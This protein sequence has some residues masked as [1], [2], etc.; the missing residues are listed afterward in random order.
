VFLAFA[1]WFLRL[2]GRLDLVWLELSGDESHAWV[3]ARTETGPLL[4]EGL[5]RIR[6]SHPACPFLRGLKEHEGNGRYRLAGDQVWAFLDAVAGTR[7]ARLEAVARVPWKKV[8]FR[9]LEVEAAIDS[10]VPSLAVRYSGQARWARGRWMRLGDEWWDARLTDEHA[11]L[12]LKGSVTYGPERLRHVLADFAP[13]WNVRGTIWK[14]DPNRSLTRAS[15]EPAED[16]SIAV[17]CEYLVRREEIR[18]LPGDAG[19][20]LVGDSVVPLPKLTPLLDRALREGPVRLDADAA[21]AFLEGEGA[22]LLPGARVLTKCLPVLTARM[23]GQDLLLEIAFVWGESSVASEGDLA[24]RRTVRRGMN[25]CRLEPAALEEARSALTAAL[26]RAFVDAR[27]EGTRLRL[28]EDDVPEFLAHG[29]GW[30]PSWKVLVPKAA[31]AVVRP[32]TRPQFRV[33]PI[34]E[35]GLGGIG[36]EVSFDLGGETFSLAEL[37]IARREGSRWARRNDR[38]IEFD[39]GMVARILELAPPRAPMDRPLPVDAHT[40]RTRV[41]GWRRIGA[42]T[43]DPEVLRLRA[44]MDAGRP[45]LA[46]PPALA[47]SSTGAM[48]IHAWMEACSALGV[49]PTMY[50]PT[51]RDTFAAMTGFLLARKERGGRG[52][53]LVVAGNKRLS[54]W[55]S[56]LST[57]LPLRSL[58]LRRKAPSQEEIAAADA[59]LV[60]PNSLDTAVYRAVETHWAAVLFDQ[61]DRTFA[62][63]ESKPYRAASRIRARLRVGLVSD[64]KALAKEPKMRALRGL[65][66]PGIEDESPAI[67]S[68]DPEQGAHL[69]PVSSLAT[70]ASRP[71]SAAPGPAYLAWRDQWRRGVPTLARPDWLRR[72]AGEILNLEEDSDSKRA[73]GKLQALWRAYRATHARI[74]EFMI[75][76]IADLY[77]LHVGAEAG[78]AWQWKHVDLAPSFPEID[79]FVEFQQGRAPLA[80]WRR[81]AG[82]RPAGKFYEEH[83]ELVDAACARAVE[84]A[85]LRP[86]EGSRRVRRTLF[87]GAAVRADFAREI[88][89]G[90][91]HR[92]STLAPEIAAILKRAESELRSKPEAPVPPPVRLELDFGRVEKLKQ[93]SD[94]VREIL[95]APEDEPVV[96]EEETIGPVRTAD[97]R[98]LYASLAATRA[99]WRD[100]DFISRQVVTDVYRGSVRNVRELEIQLRPTGRM[101]LA[102]LEEIN[103]RAT[104]RVGDALLV[105]EGETLAANEEFH[106]ELEVLI[107]GRV[108]SAE[109]SDPYR[110][111]VGRLTEA[112]KTL[113]DALCR[114]GS[115]P[116]SRADGLLRPMGAMAS[117]TAE[118]INEKALETVGDI[119]LAADGEAFAVEEDDLEPLRKATSTR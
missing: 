111:L 58:V 93:E 73:I 108:V 52:P 85:G 70:P 21:A 46:W 9:P 51:D 4:P 107:D 54:A 44:V 88:V 30:L 69:I 53:V 112:E 66:Y 5:A 84:S 103:E 104:E 83:R 14:Y 12:V 105:L 96:E 89:L 2:L 45:P 62:T 99:V 10:A 32:P 39:R 95:A 65:V 78:L 41:E 87:Q 117:L 36:L 43:V 29:T 42:V 115:L 7:M 3:I 61:I 23:D 106:D 59:V 86:P 17:R 34:R 31:P 47:A 16:G 50:A 22:A 81:L 98:V 116:S 37:A 74:D 101:P 24:G 11:E 57:L 8:A 60:A 63:D 100:L 68:H 28:R 72:H 80:A 75:D 82:V 6:A 76:W 110:A 35:D 92:W 33:I 56:G 64:R 49:N 19:W 27:V 55:T 20:A 67:F 97:G 119:V 1:R 13:L 113:V 102:T 118:S 48:R 71:G 26:R 109:E 114:E 79:L 18:P 91:A 38:W 77:Y 94:A 40:L 90:R 25:W 15:A